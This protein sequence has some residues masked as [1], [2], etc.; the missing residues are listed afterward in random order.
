MPSTFTPPK[1]LTSFSAAREAHFREPLTSAF[2]ALTSPVTWVLPEERKS[3][4][5]R[6]SPSPL[7]APA[8]LK[9]RQRTLPSIFALPEIFTSSYSPPESTPAPEIFI[10][11]F[12]PPCFAP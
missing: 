1:S 12:M 6:R 9:L 7:A 4:R 10:S 3:S 5:Q 11:M 8:Q 2:W